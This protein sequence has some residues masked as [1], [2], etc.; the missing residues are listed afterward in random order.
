M[1]K[2]KLISLIIASLLTTSCVNTMSVSSL[3]EPTHNIIR[4]NNSKQFEEYSKNKLK[5]V[6]QPNKLNYF[7]GE[8][9]EM[10]CLG[11]MYS[12]YKIW[13]VEPNQSQPSKVITILPVSNQTNYA[14]VE[15]P[16]ELTMATQK[17]AA[18]LGIGHRIVYVPSNVDR[19][20]QN[21]LYNKYD[22]FLNLINQ[23]TDLDKK[24]NYDDIFIV[25]SLIEYD[26]PN[27][28]FAD[29]IDMSSDGTKN[30]K[31]FHIGASHGK[32]RSSGR[33]TMTFSVVYPAHG[34]GSFANPQ[35]V[36][37]PDATISVSLDFKDLQN[38]NEFAVSYDGGRPT[39]GYRNKFQRRDSRFIATN[40]LIERGL[41]KVLGR[42][43]KMPYWRCM[44]E[45]LI[46]G[47][48]KQ[49]P[50]GLS[51]MKQMYGYDE[52]VEKNVR[53]MFRFIGDPNLGLA[54]YIKRP[55]RAAKNDQVWVGVRSLDDDRAKFGVDIA[56]SVPHALLIDKSMFEKNDLTRCDGK[57]ITRK[58]GTVDYT[59][60]NHCVK[61]KRLNEVGSTFQVRNLTSQES[62]ALKGKVISEKIN[63]NQTSFLELLRKVA[64]FNARTLSKDE[65]ERYVKYLHGLNQNQNTEEVFTNLWM[66]LPYQVDSRIYPHY[67]NWDDSKANMRDFIKEN[68]HLLKLGE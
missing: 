21:Q 24:R 63:V 43:Y 41:L 33:M 14:D 10:Q 37:H 64:V 15:L 5:N 51:S 23:P 38:D 56:E 50:R 65:Q 68:Q 62:N 8:N 12:A 67:L 57:I 45:N 49:Y 52:H 4:T 44:S 3:D 66:S 36:Y 59:N 46:A 47:D 1:M 61:S 18:Q 11:D 48:N 32:D 17:I 42:Y 20:D 28:I 22:S 16:A 60:Y 6:P 34:V 53:R 39:L 25:A 55:N 30:K 40:L 13:D 35:F 26:D 54:P 58:N 7:L 19:K 27:R 2:F 9:Q 31:S 29:G